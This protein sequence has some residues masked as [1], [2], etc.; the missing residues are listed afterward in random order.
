MSHRVV[1]NGLLS[2]EEVHTVIEFDAVSCSVM[3]NCGSVKLI[4]VR[5]GDLQM[6]AAV[7][8]VTPKWLDVY[9]VRVMTH[10]ID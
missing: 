8:Y 6:E 5:T 10:D 3:E 2:D 9:P 7:R 4:V 1:M